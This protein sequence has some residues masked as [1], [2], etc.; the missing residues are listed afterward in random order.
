MNGNVPN[1][2]FFMQLTFSILPFSYEFSNIEQVFEIDTFDASYDVSIF[3]G[4]VC[5]DSSLWVLFIY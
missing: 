2:Y 5:K 3:I 1:S 4:M